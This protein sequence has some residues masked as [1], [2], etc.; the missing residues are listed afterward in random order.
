MKHT[1]YSPV[2]QC[3]V[4]NI[5]PE[6]ASALLSTNNRNRRVRGWY[7]NQLA[8]A[9]MRGEWKVTSQGV[10]IDCRGNLIDAQHRLMAC[11]MSGKSFESVV[12]WG[13]PEKSFE[14]TDTGMKRSASDLL[15]ID[16]RVVE[17]VTLGASIFYGC[18]G[19]TTSEQQKKIAATGLLQS[20]A[21]LIHSC[22]TTSKVFSS[23]PV[24]LAA[25]ISIMDTGQAGYIQHQYNSIVKSN[26]GEMSPAAQALYK[27]VQAGHARSTDRY[28]L[29]ARAFKVFDP[30]LRHVSKIQIGKDDCSHAAE[31]VRRV[32]KMSVGTSFEDAFD[33]YKQLFHD[34]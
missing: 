10:G 6:L 18:G 8:D 21:M 9:M 30:T 24:K 27:Q 16:K 19:T 3:A 25:C 34:K 17:V 23:A 20:A 4:V 13:L 32:L 2:P 29:L 11:E 31:R 5:T 26:F 12:V 28:D 1:F 15:C 7:V 33:A 22:G 14:V